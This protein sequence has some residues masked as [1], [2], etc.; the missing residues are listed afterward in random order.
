MAMQL[1]LALAVF[2]TLLLYFA[3][4]A[5]AEYPIDLTLEES[6]VIWEIPEEDASEVFD[7]DLYNAGAAD[8]KTLES[9]DKPWYELPE[10][11]E[12]PWQAKPETEEAE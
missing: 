1:K 4:S 9:L 7:I 10:D 6:D 5:T 12:S 11:S 3:A 8:N 2:F